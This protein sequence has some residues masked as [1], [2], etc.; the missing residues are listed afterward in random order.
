MKY[1]LFHSSSSSVQ[2]S[3]LERYLP[4]EELAGT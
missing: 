4:F 2:I 3:A 1:P